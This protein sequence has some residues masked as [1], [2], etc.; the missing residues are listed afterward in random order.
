MI[1]RLAFSIIGGTIGKNM[2]MLNILILCTITLLNKQL[3][4]KLMAVQEVADRWN[5][6]VCVLN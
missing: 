4:S 5:K 3:E 6:K 1:E 2:R